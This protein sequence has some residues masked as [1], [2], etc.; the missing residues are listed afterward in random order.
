MLFGPPL[1]I[2][3]MSMLIAVNKLYVVNLKLMWQLNIYN[4]SELEDYMSDKVNFVVTNS[5]WDQNFDDVS[6]SI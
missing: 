1:A 6:T 5:E 4:Y 2:L 3:Y